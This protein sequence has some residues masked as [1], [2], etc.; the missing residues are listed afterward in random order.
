MI[1]VFDISSGKPSSLPSISRP[2]GNGPRHLIFSPPN[3]RSDRTLVYL[4]EEMGNTVGV[5]EVEYPSENQPALRLNAIQREVSVL[6]PDAKDTCVSLSL[7]LPRAPGF[8]TLLLAAMQPGRLD[9]RRARPLALGHVPLRDEPLARRQ[10]GAVRHA[11]HLPCRRRRLDPARRGVLLQP[12]GPRAAPLCAERRWAVPR[13]AAR[14]HERVRRVRGDAG[15]GGRA[16]RGGEAQGRQPAYV[17]R[18]A[19]VEGSEYVCACTGAL[20]VCTS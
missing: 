17:R 13:R 2:A 1:R 8:L 16:E 15:Q 20:L 12:R 6:P 19:A 14:A 18:V 7:L 4:I 5:F 11:H 3:A 9:R 10:P